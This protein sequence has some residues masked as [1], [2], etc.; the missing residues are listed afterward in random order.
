MERHVDGHEDACVHGHV[1]GHV[2]EQLETR[3]HAHVH[4][5]VREQRWKGIHMGT[6]AGKC[7]DIWTSD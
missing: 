4:A 3:V 5:N 2:D 6:Q 1:N 7:I